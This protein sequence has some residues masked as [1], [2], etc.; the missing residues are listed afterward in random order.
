MEKSVYETTHEV[1]VMMG[2]L[3]REEL[4][5]KCMDLFEMINGFG[6]VEVLH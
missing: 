3:W 5:K 4:E 2:W 6:R 1:M